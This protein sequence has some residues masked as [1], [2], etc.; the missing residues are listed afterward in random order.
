MLSI[1]FT[2][3]IGL[4]IVS[5]SLTAAVPVQ[6]VNNES[7]ALEDLLKVSEFKT[8][9]LN[10]DY[11]A[12][13]DTD[14]MQILYAVESGYESNHSNY[15][16]VIYVYNLSGR[17]DSQYVFDYIGNN[18]EF[19]SSYVAS[20]FTK[21]LNFINKSADN[22]FLK[23]RVTGLNSSD[24]VREDN[25][26][27]YGITGI[28]IGHHNENNTVSLTD[29]P[30]SKRWIFDDVNS[31]KLKVYSS[32][33]HYLQLDLHG[34]VYR[35]NSSNL[36]PQYQNDLFY[37]YFDVPSRFNGEEFN[38]YSVHANYYEFN[39]DNKI[40]AM[41]DEYD[42]SY[43]RSLLRQ[44]GLNISLPDELVNIEQQIWSHQNV[45]QN[46]FISHYVLDSYDSYFSTYGT[47][48]AYK[49][50]SWTN[51]SGGY[52]N[53]DVNLNAHSGPSTG[54][55]YFFTRDNGAIHHQ[56]TDEFI[57][58][59]IN[60]LNDSISGNVLG[61]NFD[62]ESCLELTGSTATDSFRDIHFTQDPEESHGGTFV[63][64]DLRSYGSTHNGWENFWA[65]INYGTD[66]EEESLENVACIEK[67]LTTDLAL[68]DSSFASKYLL[69]ENNVSNVKNLLGDNG[70]E[71]ESTYIFR[72]LTRPYR[73]LPLYY[74]GIIS[75][76]INL[77]QVSD[78]ECGY[79]ATN[80]TGVIDFDVIDLTF[81][82]E[83]NE[84]LHLPVVADPINIFPDLTPPI[85]TGCSNALKLL[86]WLA[87]ILLIVI[88]LVLF[89]RYVIP[90][91][92]YRKLRKEVK[93]N[94]NI[95]NN[96][97]MAA[98]NK[99]KF[100]SRRYKRYRK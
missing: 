19:Y 25:S 46:D 15:E 3:G 4:P 63:D 29:Y 43:Y 30:I 81:V 11:I 17:G 10:G 40:V 53:R 22:L 84:V 88:A 48:E 87:I 8:A 94:S 20:G 27:E 38:L 59:R 49:K 37:A 41:L 9:Y 21:K 68:N 34:G 95:K 70:F 33:Y 31:E 23:Y 85:E 77:Y 72:F 78:W 45:N 12:Q 83:S 91:I 73:A 57:P 74:G 69:N 13:G 71:N 7:N 82:S 65:R 39:L 66:I 55:A 24:F 26:R 42:V 58:F 14:S 1:L 50:Y 6:A 52:D 89:V 56:N 36:G 93:Q 16:L 79:I 97:K 35:T 99:Q 64:F 90:Y 28:Q 61:S 54:N 67:I 96:V 62:L 76:F 92:R 75:Q 86:M 44:Y 2:F 32:D 100:K 98:A 80:F 51:Y 5:S 18:I 47:S 60:D